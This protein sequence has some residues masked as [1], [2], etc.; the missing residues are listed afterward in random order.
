MA[1]VAKNITVTLPNNVTLVGTQNGTASSFLGVPY[2]V[3]RR[4]SA[5]G[6]AALAPH[7]VVVAQEFGFCCP[8]RPGDTTHKEHWPTDEECLSLNV[9]APAGAVRGAVA[10]LPV[11]VFIHGGAFIDGCSALDI[12]R[13][14]RFFEASGETAIVVSI[15][16]R[17]G[18][19]GWLADAHLGPNSTN[20]GFA[21]QLA[22]LQWLRDN[23]AAFGGDPGRISLF[24][25]SAGAMSTAL[26]S[27]SPLSAPHLRSILMES[28]PFAVRYRTVK[29][30][31]LYADTFA[32]YLGCEDPTI[33]RSCLAGKSWQ[34]LLAAQDKTILLPWPPVGVKLLELLPWAP[35]IDNMLISTQPIDAY[36]AGTA[37]TMPVTAGTNLNETGLW[38]SAA[39]SVLRNK[40]ELYAYMVAQWG[41]ATALKVSKLYPVDDDEPDAVTRT[42]VRLTTDFAFVCPT[43]AALRQSASSSVHAYHF[44]HFSPRNPL[45]V[46]HPDWCGTLR[47]VCHASELVYVFGSDAA[48]P[49]ASFHFTEEERALSDSMQVLWHKSLTNDLSPSDWPSLRGDGTP[50][51]A[52]NVKSQG[53]IAVRHDFDGHNCDFFDSIGYE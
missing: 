22:A 17:L 46:A 4:F 6:P 28:N 48:F 43:R 42:M 23:V 31:Q 34:A 7:S 36:M 2:G 9:W 53:G 19:F 18:I 5:P 14:T 3:A 12:L 39:A 29:E 1:I 45:A 20:V 25:E 44:E 37:P 49:N 32:R 13:P 40:A 15:N 38:G 21:D 8:S 26:H 27:V 35:V 33:R 24:G 16:Y 10:P 52:F 11:L 41:P 47:G 51:L 30:S 50:S